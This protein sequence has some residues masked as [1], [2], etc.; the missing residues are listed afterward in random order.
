MKRLLLTLLVCGC[1]AAPREISLDPTP[2]LPGGETSSLYHSALMHYR[3]HER[4]EAI[5]FARYAATKWEEEK[6]PRSQVRL[7]RELLARSLAENGDKSAALAE[8]QKLS[9]EFPGV[10]SYQ[11]AVNSLSR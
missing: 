7:A 8:Y 11:Q 1:T 2:P 4:K 9:Q 10:P 3:A 5:L 6:A